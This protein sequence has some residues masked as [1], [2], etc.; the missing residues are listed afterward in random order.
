[1]DNLVFSGTNILLNNGTGET[2]T[3]NGKGNLFLGYNAYEDEVRTGSHNLIIGDHNAFYGTS[4]LLVGDHHQSR[5]E[6]A[7]PSSAE[8]RTFSMGTVPSLS[9]DTRPTSPATSPSFGGAHN[10]VEAAYGLALGGWATTPSWRNSPPPAPV[11]RTWRQATMHSPWWRAQHRQRRIIRRG[12]R[13][14]H[15]EHRAPRC[16]ASPISSHGRGRAFA[17]TTPSSVWLRSRTAAA[18]SDRVDNRGSP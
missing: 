7:R 2:R 17:W 1:M 11:R 12:W 4:G 3:P 16:G 15:R 14:R 9:P 13:I 8:S 10:I 5:A 18:L 6:M